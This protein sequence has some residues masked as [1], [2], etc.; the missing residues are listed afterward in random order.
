MKGSF[1]E[2]TKTI[3]LESDTPPIREARTASRTSN[4]N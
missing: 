2:N 1:V 3:K 4:P